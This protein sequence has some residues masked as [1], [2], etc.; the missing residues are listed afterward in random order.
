MKILIA[1]DNID[2]QGL[3]KRL[4]NYWGF[5]FDIAPNGQEAIELAKTNEG[6]YD[7]CLMDI[8]MPIMTGLE[9]TKIIRHRMKYL[10]IMALTGNA[11]TVD[12]YVEIGMDDFL[13]KP[14]TPGK[15]YD[16]I[17]ELTVKVTTIQKERNQIVIRKELP[18][19][20]EELKELRELDKKGLAKFSLID[21]GYKFIVH[22]NLQ[23][24]LSH[25]FIAKR[26]QL[27]E[28]LDRSTDDPGIIHLYASNLHA[29]KR[30]IL[31]EILDQLVGAEDKDMKDYTTKAE[32][33]EKENTKP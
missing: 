26:K 30:H 25:E 10:P 27:A 9:A 23:N 5:D 11:L 18:V 7:L 8:D 15:L 12:Q 16:K 17:S 22:K 14:Y 4:M 33:P 21:T 24:K 28:F 32:Y 6:E 31:P 20:S 29:S 19:D 1:E 3:I 2:L 13:Q